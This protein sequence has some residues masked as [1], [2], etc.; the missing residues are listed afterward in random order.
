MV[1][2]MIKEVIE[3]GKGMIRC[4]MLSAVCIFLV[5][6]LHHGTAGT[7]METQKDTF[8]AGANPTNNPIGGGKGYKGVVTWGDYQVRNLDQLLVALRKAKAGEIIYIDNGAVIDMTGKRA[9]VIPGGVTLAS[10]RGDSPGALIF[11]NEDKATPSGEQDPSKIERFYLFE[12]GGLNV[13]VTGLRLRGPDPERRGRYAFINSD[14]IY[15]VHSGLEVDNCELWAW[16]H[17]AVFLK[18]GKDVYIHHNYIHHCQRSGLGYGVVLDQA[19][20]VIEANIFDWCRHAIA[21]TGRTNSG[22]EARY[23][24]VLENANGHS[25][26]MHGGA[27]RKDG[28]N[29]AGDWISIHHNTFHARV[30]PIVIRGRPTDKCEIHHNWFLHSENVNEAVFQ[31][32]AK[33]NIKVFQNQFGKEK[34]IID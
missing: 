21:G 12:A 7:V 32:N 13:R 23:N 15:S 29:V 26:D 24:V 1:G 28:T 5:T 2:K 18:K 19:E 3:V 34:T 16:S 27:D 33:G 20:A 30:Q 10:G 25:F 31:F 9:I 14:G 4:F 22:Y 17:G 8:G 6:N 11:T